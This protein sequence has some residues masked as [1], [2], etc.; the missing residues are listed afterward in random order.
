LERLLSSN[1]P[2]KRQQRNRHS[3]SRAEERKQK[4][5]K[6]NRQGQKSKNQKKKLTTTH[7]T[8]R[9]E[10]GDKEGVPDGVKN[11]NKHKKRDFY[12]TIKKRENT[13]MYF[14]FLERFFPPL[15]PKRVFQRTERKSNSNP[16]ELPPSPL[17]EL[18]TQTSGFFTC[19]F[20][21]WFQRRLLFFF[22]LFLSPSK[23]HRLPCF[24][25]YSPSIPTHPPIENTSSFV[26]VFLPRRP[27][28]KHLFPIK[29]LIVLSFSLLPTPAAL[30]FFS[31]VCFST[32][33]SPSR[34]FFFSRR[35]VPY[36]TLYEVCRCVSFRLFFSFRS[37]FQ[38][39][40]RIAGAGD[41]F[42]RRWQR[43]RRRHTEWIGRIRPRLLLLMMM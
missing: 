11:T 33:F 21:G 29:R 10:K 43:P 40:L 15:Q 12:V 39:I 23:L 36:V 27:K 19:E 18:A 1:P 34:F 42:R 7:H 41:N 24:S 32:N 20:V 28:K 16:R 9:Y 2:S 25:S 17:H 6:P 22:L 37:H 8:K 26:C 31:P 35:L 38:W 14:L 5:Y 3:G 13:R 4:N 30:L